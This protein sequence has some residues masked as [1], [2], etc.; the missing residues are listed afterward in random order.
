[1]ESS[2]HS[3]KR[4]IPYAS[5]SWT[6]QLEY[7]QID[8]RMDKERCKSARLARMGS[9]T[10]ANHSRITAIAI[11]QAVLRRRFHCVFVR[12]VSVLISLHCIFIVPLNLAW[13]CA[14][15]GGLATLSGASWHHVGTGL[16][17]SSGHRATANG[18]RSNMTRGR[19]IGQRAKPEQICQA[20]L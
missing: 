5:P 4:E 2:I 18:Q 7:F 19:S 16:V 6:G 20:T 15:S 12:S 14:M 9:K 13:G 17:V 10:T 3:R 8:E 11:W 1:M